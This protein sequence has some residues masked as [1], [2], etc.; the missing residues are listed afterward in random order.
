MT[1]GSRKQ[2]SAQRGQHRRAITATLVA[3]TVVLVATICSTAAAV[4]RGDC[5]GRIAFDSLRSGNG[6]I[7]VI[8]APPYPPRTATPAPDTTPTRLTASDAPDVKPSWSP[9]SR[10]GC[11][12]DPVPPPTLIAFQR[13]SNGNTD[14]YRLDPASPEPTGTP[15]R[16]TTDPAA[17]TAP[18]WAPDSIP[19][20]PSFDYPPIAFERNI[21]GKRDIFI[22]TF[23]GAIESNL[24]STDDVDEANP[25]W[26]SRSSYLTFDSDQGGRREIWVMD[27]IY[28]ANSGEF[29]SL[30]KRQVTAGPA[31]SSFNPSW[32]MFTEDLPNEQNPDPI[33]WIAFAG[34]DTDGGDSQI[35]VVES[36][37]VGPP[38]SQV[39]PNENYRL[40]TN[41]SDD[42]AP[43]WS[44][45]GDRIAYQSN[46][47][48]NAEIY[49]MDPFEEGENDVNLTQFP[50]SDQNPDWEAPAG[51]T[52]V[53][54]PVRPRGRRSRQRRARIASVAPPPP[55][56]PSPPGERGPMRPPP[57]PGPD[58]PKLLGCTISGTA[59]SDM[60]RGTAK[61]DVICGNGGDDRIVGLGGNDVIRGDAG[62]DRIKG[63][64]GDD[65]ISGGAGNDRLHGGG[66][67]DNI[68]GG[69]G[70]DRIN[71]KD[72]QRDRVSGGPGR[73]RA[74]VDRRDR[75]GGVE[76]LRR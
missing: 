30:A 45:R 44:P 46:R 3:L 58:T 60:L 70:R 56:Q 42:T 32:F 26:S 34:T 5:N 67:H 53:A 50:G 18:V 2:D 16:V 35:H 23:D 21:N 66:G 36:P 31:G 15:E 13:T 55:S 74:A 43:A 27:V 49:V 17:D 4:P 37:R 76:S 24:T 71:A 9:P 61:R 40:T 7:Y 69:R 14:I 63:S 22:A 48:G 19:G 54:F 12:A 10:S 68:G 28:N 51:P 52:A 20:S 75:V 73:D 64:S 8:D 29:E 39:D 33:D 57:R 72:R 59:R 62:N 6:D 38:F 1:P 11:D 41:P 65:Q 47:D 25:E